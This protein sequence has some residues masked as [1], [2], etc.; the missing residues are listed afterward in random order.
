[1]DNPMVDAFLAIGSVFA[2]CFVLGFYALLAVM[3]FSKGGK[4]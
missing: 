3:A 4:R 2:G 1:M